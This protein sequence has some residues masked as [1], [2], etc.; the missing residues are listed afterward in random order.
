MRQRNRSC[1]WNDVKYPS[2]AHAAKALGIT[3]EAMRQRVNKGYV[4]DDDLT[5]GAKKPK[6]LPLST[7]EKEVIR[8]YLASRVQTMSVRKIAKRFGVKMTVIETLLESQ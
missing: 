5:A 1:V 8:R 6:P 4:C 2:M 7:E 3:K